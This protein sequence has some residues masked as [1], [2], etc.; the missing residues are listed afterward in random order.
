MLGDI[1][2]DLLVH[3]RDAEVAGAE[4]GET[5]ADKCADKGNCDGDDNTEEV[6]KEE[7][8]VSVDESVGDKIRVDSLGAKQS[9]HDAAVDTADAVAA[10]SVKGIV[11]AEFRFELGY[12]VVAERADQKADDEGGPGRYKAAAGGDG[13][14]ADNKAGAAPTR[15]GFPV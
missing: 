2:A 1:Q 15:V 6:G 13:D 11:V 4:L 12:A 10:E 3:F 14:K 7:L 5:D 9:G 8:A